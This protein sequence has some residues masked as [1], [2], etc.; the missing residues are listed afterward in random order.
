MQHASAWYA[1]MLKHRMNQGDFGIVLIRML[2]RAMP[3][4]ARCTRI[5][6]CRGHRYT[7]LF[8]ARIA[9]RNPRQN[10]FPYGY[11]FLAAL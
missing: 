2:G 7:L 5:Y 9:Q 11:F 6:L 8:I 1:R 10:R 3:A 4:R